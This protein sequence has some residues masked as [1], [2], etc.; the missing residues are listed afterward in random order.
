[1]LKQACVADLRH[2]RVSRADGYIVLAMRCYPRGVSK[3]LRDEYLSCL[4][5]PA[6]LLNDLHAHKQDTSHNEAFDRANY[7][8]RFDLNAD[9]R[10]ALKRLVDLSRTRDVYLICQCKPDEKCHRE[11]L[12]LLAKKWYK[13]EVQELRFGYPKFE[14][15][16]SPAEG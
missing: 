3:T 8:E 14:E 9:G 10:E 5:P 2:A 11:L 16:L 12:L 6:E 4:G 13:A 1:M 15:R 7:E